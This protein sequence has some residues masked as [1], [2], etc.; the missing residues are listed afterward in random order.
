MSVRVARVL[1]IAVASLVWLAGC[2]SWKGLDVW[3]E[4]QAAT[5]ADHIATGAVPGGAAAPGLLGS[6]PD[7]DLSL[8]KKH[9]R[10]SNFGLAEKH[11]RRAVEQHPKDAEAWV[12]LAAA[13]D[14][15][16]R[17][18]LAD[19]AYDTAVQLVGQTP[20]ILNNQGFSYLLRGDYRRA[21]TMFLAAQAKDPA[22]AYARAN[23]KLLE[24]AARKRKGVELAPV[25]RKAGPKL[26]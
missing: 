14:R 22:N 9:Y 24:E 10:V 4:N 6:D 25:D 16:K 11:F 15:L 7:D 3:G 20:E 12:G 17:F 18:D 23:L 5:G 13:Y 19:R 2:E 8:G 21:R 26:D 1:V